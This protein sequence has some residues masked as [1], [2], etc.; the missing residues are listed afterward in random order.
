MKRVDNA[1]VDLTSTNLKSNQKAISEFTSLLGI[2][3]TKLQDLLRLKLG[4]HVNPIE[5]LH[6]L[7]KGTF[8]AL[9]FRNY[10]YRFHPK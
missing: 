10:A 7:T 3:N 1:L 6:Y 5:P 2:G 8:L 9:F 4:Q